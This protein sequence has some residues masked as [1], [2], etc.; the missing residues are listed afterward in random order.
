M[1][2]EGKP[3]RVYGRNREE[4]NRITSLDFEDSIK[5]LEKL[6]QIM[7][8]LKQLE[9]QGKIEKQDKNKL[10]SYITSAT[11]DKK[12]NPTPS[13]EKLTK[14]LLSELKKYNKGDRKNLPEGW[15]ADFKKGP[16]KKFQEKL[17][18]MTEPYDGGSVTRSRTPETAEFWKIIHRDFTKSQHQY[19]TYPYKL[20]AEKLLNNGFSLE[21]IGAFLDE[22]SKVHWKPVENV[23]NKVS[24]TLDD[25]AK[26]VE[27]TNDAIDKAVKEA[28]DSVKDTAKVVKPPATTEVENP[29]VDVLKKVKKEQSTLDDF[30]KTAKKEAKTP[31]VLVG[32]QIRKNLKP[33]MVGNTQGKNNA[34]TIPLLPAPKRKGSKPIIPSLPIILPLPKPSG[35]LPPPSKVPSELLPSIR[36]PKP[37]K[38]PQKGEVTKW[39]PVIEVETVYEGPPLLNFFKFN[40]GLILNALR[41]IT[42]DLPAI[43]ALVSTISTYY[44]GYMQGAK[45]G[46]HISDV[47]GFT[48]TKDGKISSTITNVFSSV[49]GIIGG[50]LGGPAGSIVGKMLGGVAAGEAMND[51]GGPFA[52]IIGLLGM[53]VSIVGTIWKTL[54]KSS[55]ILQAI[56]DLFN[57]AWTL[58]FMPFG[59]A[60]GTILLPIMEAVVELAILFNKFSTVLFQPIADAI[61][62]IITKISTILLTGLEMLSPFI[63]GTLL[64]IGEA[65]AW[66]INNS[67]PILDLMAEGIKFVAQWF[68]LYGATF[69]QN[70]Q[71]I[72]DSFVNLSK[73]VDYE[74]LFW[75]IA[76][77]A[78]TVGSALANVNLGQMV[79]DIR[80]IVIFLNNLISNPIET[81][82]G[83]AGNWFLENSKLGT[84][85]DNIKGVLGLA[86]GGVVTSATLA[87]I[88]EAGPEAVIPLDKMGAMGA[89][90]VNINGDVYG[91]SDLENRIERV[92]QR[93]ANKSSYR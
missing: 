56:S 34:Q 87:V 54:K 21:S 63:E 1:F 32:E 44:T 57:L 6:E 23:I 30:I 9:K 84:A 29:V 5:L 85:W 77:I 33:S 68:S 27:K 86:T 74:K 25:V 12:G 7:D 75:D 92:I 19:L 58:F 38:K 22:D 88:G 18:I 80:G 28:T 39:Q 93:T 15:Y 47:T 20:D 11:T 71:S 36:T 55:P 46:S 14:E 89:T 37:L 83:A 48:D 8:S 50:I 45:I 59:N 76:S 42:K 61:A 17:R 78:T 26:T 90:I 53:A 49:G 82:G 70:I 4:K 40:K 2:D 66:L 67:T 10:L 60:L 72:V 3:E 79:S 31:Y 91:V 73:E 65:V 41:S 51:S 13:M 69:L 24:E 52:T 43:N 81:A 16:L 64:L 62:N 35:L